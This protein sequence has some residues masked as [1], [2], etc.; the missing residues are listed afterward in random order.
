[1]AA[2]ENPY[3]TIRVV[4][5][6]TQRGVPMVELK[7][8]NEITYYTDSQGIVAFYEPGLMDI[9]VFFSIASPGYSYP[10]D[11]FGMRG[12]QLRPKSGEEAVV[13]IQ[14]DQPAERLYR[15]TGQGIYRDSVLVKKTT[16][17]EHNVLNGQVM[18]QD[19]TQ[20][21]IYNDKIYWFWG[22]TSRP[23][24][25][26]GNFRMSGATSELP[27]KGGLSPDRGIELTY[28]VNEEGFC[29]PMCPI[30]E[31]GLIWADG[32]IVVN[33]ETGGQRMIA[34]YSHRESLVKEL[35]HG[36]VIFDESNQEFTKLVEFDLDQPW[37]CPQG[38][39]IRVREGEQDYF[40]FPR[41]FPTV[42][43]PAE[44][45]RIQDPSAYEA[46]TCL[47]TGTSFQGADS[48]LDLKDGKVVYSW[49]RGTPPLQ[50]NEENELVKHGLLSAEDAR[51]LPVD[52]QRGV[53]IV[54]HSG[55]V[56]WNAYRDQWI[57]IGVEIGGASF[58]GEV[59]YLESRSPVGPWKIARKV[60]THNPY[61]F[62]NPVHHPF[63]DQENGRV[64]YFE[65]TYSKM[66]SDRQTA[67]PWY[68]YNQLMYRLDLGKLNIQ[69]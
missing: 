49:K 24:Y 30:K 46:F 52:E 67:T 68:D 63:F 6:E 57:M 45:D 7:T 54:I 48:K 4:D 9:D 18:G 17:I 10:A 44:I 19:S 41:P 25:P 69:E 51:F 50:P 8:T 38:H 13:A 35:E 22:D 5:E 3:F 11:G 2:D 27:G 47:Q 42:R 1:M 16:P 60:A 15:I 56:N 61:T 62:Y 29:K 40:Y 21:A 20:V 34:H 32:F 23:Q 64:I 12:K 28:F 14:R 43:A 39:P 26:L 37:Q 59:W 65:G 36:L 33:D 55:S 31:S 53:P 66:F 58:L